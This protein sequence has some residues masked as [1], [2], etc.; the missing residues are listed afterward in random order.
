M[1]R[2]AHHERNQALAV[3]PELVEGLVQRFPSPVYG[4]TTEQLSPAGRYG[5]AAVCL[6]VG[7]GIVALATG[8]IPANEAM[9]HAPHWVLGACG[10]VFILAAVMILV[11]PAML[12]V[13]YF[14]GAVLL[15]LF[16]AIPGWIAFGPGPRAFSGSVSIGVITNATQPDASTG[17]I[18]FGIAAVL[19]GSFAAYAWVRWLRSM[20]DPPDAGRSE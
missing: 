15:S 7:A 3:R 9:F 2:Q 12:R 19:I 5:V 4:Q 11:P 14:L 6:L 18:V 17:R 20:F 1:V 8:A 10:F 16:A 13:Q